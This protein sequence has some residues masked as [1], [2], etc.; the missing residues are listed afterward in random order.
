M[1]F[2]FVLIYEV[3]SIFS[4]YQVLSGRSEWLDTPAPLNAIVKF[5]VC[6]AVGNLIA[7]FYVFILMVKLAVKIATGQLF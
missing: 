2:I 6:L 7:A 1:E 5:V 4:G 3:V